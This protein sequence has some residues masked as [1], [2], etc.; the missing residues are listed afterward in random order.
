M[1]PHVTTPLPSPV[2]APRIAHITVEDLEAILARAYVGGLPPLEELEAG[3]L[4]VLA[5]V[6]RAWEAA[7]E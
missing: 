6:K 4:E 2:R 7:T 3:E 1:S 5:R